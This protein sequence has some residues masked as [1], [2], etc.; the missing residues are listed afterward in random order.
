MG[1]QHCKVGIFGC[2][3]EYIYCRVR[4]SE[5]KAEI[6]NFLRNCVNSGLRFKDIVKEATNMMI[7]HVGRTIEVKH[8]RES[9]KVF[10]DGTVVKN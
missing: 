10:T 6:N 8:F 1:K 4:T 5:G 9:V 7:E 2:E 3:S